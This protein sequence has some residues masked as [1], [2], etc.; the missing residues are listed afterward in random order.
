MK[1]KLHILFYSVMGVPA[2]GLLA[3]TAAQCRAI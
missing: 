1:P 2:S 3:A